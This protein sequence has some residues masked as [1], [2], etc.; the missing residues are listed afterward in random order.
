ML[1]SLQLTISIKLITRNFEYALWQVE[2]SH[3][4]EL[5]INQQFE[6]HVFVLLSCSNYIV[7]SINLTWKRYAYTYQIVKSIRGGQH[8]KFI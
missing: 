6:K 1:K 3:V 4:L 8:T 2:I 5:T 7:I